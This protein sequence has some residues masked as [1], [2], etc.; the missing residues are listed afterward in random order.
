VSADSTD[1]Q[2]KNKNRRHDELIK[3]AISIG[4]EKLGVE[5]IK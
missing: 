2:C 1:S 3:M 4:I 5:K